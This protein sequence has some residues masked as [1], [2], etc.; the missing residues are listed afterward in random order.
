MQQELEQISQWRKACVFF[1]HLVLLYRHVDDLILGAKNK[2]FEDVLW[3]YRAALNLKA[4]RAVKSDFSVKFHCRCM[5]KCAYTAGTGL[6]PRFSINI[7]KFKNDAVRSGN[8][9]MKLLFELKA[10][11][12]DYCLI[13]LCSHTVKNI[14]AVGQKL[15]HIFKHLC[16]LL[17]FLEMLW[18]KAVWF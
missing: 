13:N 3:I 6:S 7:D 8:Y 5:Q 2:R 12:R 16:K 1:V 9:L 17:S 11:D 4:Q 15:F 18:K 10:S 14:F